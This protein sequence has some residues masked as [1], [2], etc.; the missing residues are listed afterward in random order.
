M[1]DGTGMST[2]VENILRLNN[3][4]S[5][6]ENTMQEITIFKR[7]VFQLSLAPLYLCGRQSLSKCFENNGTT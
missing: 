5:W 2:K 3:V 6:Y 4:N 1:A 7:K